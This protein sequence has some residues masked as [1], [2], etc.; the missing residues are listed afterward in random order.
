MILSHAHEINREGN[1]HET[2][3]KGRLGW[4]EP[5]KYTPEILAGTSPWSA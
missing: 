5:T 2:I 4:F 3:Y 1:N